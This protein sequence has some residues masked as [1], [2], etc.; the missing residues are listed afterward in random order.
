LV[1][2]ERSS[3]ASGAGWLGNDFCNSC[4]TFSRSTLGENSSENESCP[5]VGM[6]KGTHENP[7]LDVVNNLH[8]VGFTRSPQLQPRQAKIRNLDL[9]SKR[10][11]IDTQIS[12]EHHLET[13]SIPHNVAV[14]IDNM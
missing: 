14:V 4:I 9:M 13:A 8:G 3:E 1:N 6:I 2:C 5:Q 7:N 12:S 11:D 10:S